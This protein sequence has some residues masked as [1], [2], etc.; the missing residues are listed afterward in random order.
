MFGLSKFWN[1]QFIC[2]EV[3]IVEFA[4]EYVATIKPDCEDLANR[5]SGHNNFKFTKLTSVK[6]KDVKSFFMFSR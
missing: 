5:V 3:T 4:S 2:R 6:L 1:L